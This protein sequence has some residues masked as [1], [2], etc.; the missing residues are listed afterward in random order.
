MT[1]RSFGED[2][3]REIA[4]KAIMWIPAIAGALLL[5]PVGV[6]LG[7]TTSVAILSSFCK[8]DSEN[9]QGQVK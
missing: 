5:G 9:D 6:V 7:L 2:V 1:E 4:G 3:A 8:N